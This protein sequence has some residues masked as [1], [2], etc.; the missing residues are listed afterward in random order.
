MLSCLSRTGT[1]MMCQDATRR[2]RPKRS[3]SCS[4]WTS[5]QGS[6]KSST[7]LSASYS[8]SQSTSA[9][10][11]SSSARRSAQPSCPSWIS[12]TTRTAPSSLRVTSNTRNCRFQISCQPIS[13]P[14]QMYW[15]GRQAT[16]STLPLCYAPSSLVRVT[17]PM[18][19]M[20][21]LQK[22]SPPRMSL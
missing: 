1:S 5:T 10:S 6:S 8:C 7:I 12:T 22:R 20:V 14:L 11:R 17:M 2:T 13:P 15:S 9:T 18:L 3:W 4:M 21:R 16:P 19:S